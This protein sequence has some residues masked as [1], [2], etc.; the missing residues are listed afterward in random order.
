MQWHR[1]NNVK[2][3]SD[4]QMQRGQRVRGFPVVLQWLFGGPARNEMVSTRITIPAVPAQVWSSMQLYEEVTGRPPLILRAF[5]PRPLC[6]DG[7]K[8]RA[9]ELVRCVYD[10]GN[11]IKRIIS[12]EPP[13][14]MVF[15]VLEQRLGIEGCIVAQRGSY[16]IDRDPVGSSV[17]LTTQYRAFLH[18]RWLWR[19]LERFA[20]HQL[21]L[22]ILHGMQAKCSH[23]ANHPHP[24]PAATETTD[25]TARRSRSAQPGKPS[26]F[27]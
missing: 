23:S 7:R 11:L 10:C 4:T 24:L 18:P 20:A 14:R 6:T 21:H 13:Y 19:N 5:M 17:I 22:H 16:E 26:I 12:I 3:A 2:S 15:D 27:V 1:M 8:D 25:G 9:G